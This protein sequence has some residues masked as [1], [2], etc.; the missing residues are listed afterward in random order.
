MP[1]GTDIHASIHA[2]EEEFS[3]LSVVNVSAQQVTGMEDHVL[4]A[5][6]LKFGAAQD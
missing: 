1:F 2:V 5:Q 4:F 3:I 6:I